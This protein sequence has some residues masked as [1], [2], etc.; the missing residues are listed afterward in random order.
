MIDA[1]FIVV[2]DQIHADAPHM[3]DM[4]ADVSGKWSAAPRVSPGALKKNGYEDLGDLAS[5]KIQ[6]PTTLHAITPARP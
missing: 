3:Y 2:V 1:N 6:Q 4:A 5:R